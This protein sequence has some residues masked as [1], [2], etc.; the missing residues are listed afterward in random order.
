MFPS[1]VL[2]AKLSIFLIFPQFGAFKALKNAKK[3]H[4]LNQSP[5]CI[6][7]SAVPLP[8]FFDIIK[9]QKVAAAPIGDKA[10]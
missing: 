10:L 6:M 3:P 5:K 7:R 8:C 2:F 9:S 1:A 4:H